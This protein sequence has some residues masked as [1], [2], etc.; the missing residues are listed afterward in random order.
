[1]PGTGPVI[2][3]T[4]REIEPA[5]PAVAR[6]EDMTEQSQAAV[7]IQNSKDFHQWALSKHALHKHDPVTG[8]IPSST[9]VPVLSIQDDNDVVAF[10]E[11]TIVM[12]KNFQACTGM[13]LTMTIQMQKTA[14]RILSSFGNTELCEA[15]R[16]IYDKCLR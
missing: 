2:M 8:A 9:N 7:I 13:Q 12:E 14:E 15:F 1:M 11:N 4:A 16:N 3:L 5:A 10:Y 6:F